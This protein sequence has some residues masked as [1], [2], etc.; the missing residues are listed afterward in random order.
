MEKNGMGGVTNMI[1]EIF[2]VVNKGDVM[3]HGFAT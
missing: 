3:L 1:T 2:L